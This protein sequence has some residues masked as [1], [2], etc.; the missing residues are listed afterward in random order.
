MGRNALPE[1]PGNIPEHPK[2]AP[3]R[4]QTAP[5]RPKRRP[6]R[7]R[8]LQDRPKTAQDGPKTAQDSSKTAQE[9]PKT[10]QEAHKTAQEATKTAH[11][12]PKT[13][14]RRPKKRPRRPQDG[15]RG[16]QS[17]FPTSAQ[18]R[19]RLEEGSGEAQGS[20][21]DRHL[22]SQG[23]PAED[24]RRYNYLLGVVKRQSKEANIDL[25]RR[26]ATGPAIFFWQGVGPQ[27]LQ[28]HQKPMV[29][30]WFRPGTT[31]FH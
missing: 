21:R 9:A 15:P 23:S 16:P 31:E 22:F 25:T 10:A 30:T 17:G 1:H 24:K 5:R 7:F 11:E 20:L 18:A 3:R 12:A 4:P 19:G 27:L 14:P 29:F 8:R 28:Q 2:A 6:R 13:T 26:W